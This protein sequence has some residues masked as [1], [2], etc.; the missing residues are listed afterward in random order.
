MAKSMLLNVLE[1]TLTYDNQQESDNN[2][3]LLTVDFTGVGV[4]TWAKWLDIRLADGTGAP[5]SL[6]LGIIPTYNIPAQFMKEG[7]MEIQAYAQDGANTYKSKVFS[8]T[9]K[10]SLDIVDNTATYDPTTLGT[11]QQ[12]ISDME[13]QI[14]EVYDAYLAGQFDATIAVGTVSTGT[15]GSSVIVTNTGTNNDAVLNFTIPRGETGLTG[16][17]GAT[18]ATG[19]SG[20]YVGTSEPVDPEQIVWVD[21]DGT[22]DLP[23]VYVTEL[24]SG[25]ETTLHKHSATNIPFTPT[26]NL[27]STNVQNALTETDQRIDNIVTTPVPVGEIIAQEIIDARQGALSL[28]ANITDIKSQSADMS[29]LNLI[30]VAT[31]HNELIPVIPDGVTDNRIAIQTIIDYA[32]ANNFEGIYIPYTTNNY[33]ISVNH[34]GI[35]SHLGN[36]L[37][38]PSNFKLIMDN[39]TT[40]EAITTPFTFHVMI[41]VYD[42][43]NVEISG[44]VLIGERSSHGEIVN[45]FGYGLYIWGSENV[46]VKNV[47]SKDWWGDCFTTRDID[48]NIENNY[49]QPSKNITFENV[50]ADNGCRQGL[51]VISGKTVKVLN[52]TFKN[53]IGTAP[54]SGIDLEPNFS[55][56]DKKLENILVDNCTFENNVGYGVVA[57]NTIGLNIRNCIF[58]SDNISLLPTVEDAIIEN[59]NLLNCGFEISSKTTIIKD[60]IIKDFI[61]SMGVFY[62][63]KTDD[64]L[65][66]IKGNSVYRSGRGINLATVC[67][68]ISFENNYIYGSTVGL[69]I[70]TGISTDITF[71][72]NKFEKNAGYGYFKLQNSFIVDNIFKDNLI[73]L[74]HDGGGD[75]VIQDNVFLVGDNTLVG[76]NFITITSIVVGSILDGNKLFASANDNIVPIAITGNAG[77]TTPIIV[78][79]NIS[80]KATTIFSTPPAGTVMANNYSA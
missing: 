67:K 24:I 10:R 49:L 39:H 79:N 8:V 17:T 78:R 4:D 70:C 61:S 77:R 33:R 23:E 14:D 62:I 36:G 20:V 1:N 11:L 6:G 58:K 47:I 55:T 54:Q 28:G 80:M 73:S 43:K 69:I 5:I 64:S 53:T 19:N 32:S 60:N 21:T 75:T 16:A 22:P 27:S 40:L 18:G 45:E 38:I 35:N 13:I 31:P 37:K 41:N 50:V 71:I 25:G 29:K 3:T 66:V 63:N 48:T 76:T 2:A 34:T 30:N 7:R 59:N 26:G 56:L 68:N 57:Y 46:T 65:L 44:G 12:A 9:V 15:V 42:S 72:K 74:F 51:S 52:S